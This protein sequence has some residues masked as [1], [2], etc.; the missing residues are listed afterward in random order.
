MNHHKRSFRTALFVTTQNDDRTDWLPNVYGKGTK[1]NQTAA[2][3]N[4]LVPLAFEWRF[5][6]SEN[7][8][9]IWS[10][11]TLPIPTYSRKTD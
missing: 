4:K 7:T 2:L 11:C 10:C 6:N 5:R 9:T 8:I 3:V 1:Q